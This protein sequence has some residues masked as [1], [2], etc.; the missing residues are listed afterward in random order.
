M[1]G[2]AD[3]KVNMFY[4]ECYLHLHQ[5]VAQRCHQSLCGTE[6]H[7]EGS[8]KYVHPLSEVLNADVPFT[9]TAKYSEVS[10]GRPERNRSDQ[11]TITAIIGCVLATV[12]VVLRVISRWTGAGGQW[13]VDDFIIVPTMFVSILVQA[14]CSFRHMLMHLSF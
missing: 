6:L 11:V 13:G 4:H 14:T 10:C 2:G 9:A 3:P 12:S 5:P 1:Y 7:S 8:S